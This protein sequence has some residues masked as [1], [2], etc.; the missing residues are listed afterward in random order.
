MGKPGAFRE[1]PRRDP[2]YRDAGER[3][4][5]FRAVELVLSDDEV[6]EQ[7]CRCMECGTP[8]CHG[9][10]CPLGNLIPEF[11]D[12][13]FRHRW[14]EAL[15]LLLA[16]NNFPEFTGRI[17]PALCEGS[18]VLGI[19]RDP[20]AIR[21]IE[22]ALIE[23]G[24]EKGYIQPAPPAHRFE[25]RVAVIGSGPA[26]LTVADTLNKKGYGVVVFDAAKQPGGIL[27][28]GIPD[29]KLEKRVIDRRIRL[30]KDEGVAF[31]MGAHI[32]EDVSF[33]YLAARFDAICLASG[34]R[35][36]RDLTEVPGRELKGIHLAM[37]Y[38]VQQNRRLAG[39]PVVPAD[40]ITAEGRNVVVIGGGDTGADCLGTA[41]RQNAKR[42]LQFEIMPEPPP[43]RASSTPWPMWPQMRRESSSHKEGGERRWCVL[44]KEFLG[45]G[46][47]VR[48]MR[49]V[50]VEWLP[51]DGGKQPAM[52]ERPGTE[53][54]VEADL[55][56][57]AMGFV[58]PKRD[59]LV[60]SLHLDLDSRGNVR[61]DASGMTTVP[62]VFV[63]GD[64]SQGA[65]LVVR[66]M[67]DGR[68]VAEGIMRYLEKRRTEPPAD[69][70]MSSHETTAV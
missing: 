66:A 68:L 49:C 3:L 42:V 2:R 27:R 56:L 54:E 14:K 6:Y 51:A 22:L 55:V 39:E 45:E 15:D 40:E 29:F 57:L 46:G 8:F 70:T 16:T 47:R 10:G 17:C 11:N 44:T 25:A 59:R 5:D 9:C 38:L 43:T 26:G 36:P 64:M 50:E 60:E 30:M 34:A 48:G 37:D 13:V 28:Y 65:S 19:N 58:G 21:Q 41:L 62:G 61:R 32:G 18:C 23:K 69:D 31:E 24:F 52:R 67:A 4:R 33:Q 1:Y 63:S 7:A 20:V 35:E 12:L 53:F